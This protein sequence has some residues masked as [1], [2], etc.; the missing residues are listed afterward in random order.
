MTEKPVDLDAHRG[1]AALKATEFRRKRLNQ[2]EKNQAELRRQQEE[3]E[4]FLLA[5]PA[6]TWSE[7]AA[8][9]SY[10]IKLFAD[11]PEGQDPR[12]RK[13][14][15]HVLEDLARLCDKTTGRE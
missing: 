12:R 2:F 9:A 7:A 14:I 11:T 3:L 15:A 5:A 10:L 13:L 6:E 8:M 1:M 4:V